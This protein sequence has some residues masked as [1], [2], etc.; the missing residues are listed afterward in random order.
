[1]GLSKYPLLW[2]IEEAVNA[3]LKVNQAPSTARLGYP[4]Q[5]QPV[6]LCR[7][8]SGAKLHDSLHGAWWLLE[9]LPKIAKYKEW[10]ERDAHFGPTSPTPSRGRSRRAPIHESVV[11]RMDDQATIAR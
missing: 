10:P 1:M 4:A 2:M 8:D 3:G 11:K 7:A 9:F 6:L 5:E